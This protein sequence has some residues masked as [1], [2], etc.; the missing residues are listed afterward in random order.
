M[1]LALLVIGQVSGACTVSVNHPGGGDAMLNTLVETVAHDP[2]TVSCATTGP[3]AAVA[4]DPR[5]PD[6]LG[7]GPVGPVPDLM[8][9]E[10]FD[11][12]RPLRSGEATWAPPAGRALL[13]LLCVART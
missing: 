8:L 7:S 11:G 12:H 13:E 9:A 10:P 3:I 6:D 1:L 5:R 4:A 2:V